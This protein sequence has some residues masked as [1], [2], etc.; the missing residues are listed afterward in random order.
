MKLFDELKWRG[1]IQDV[2][3]PKL[4]EMI[5]KGDLTFYIGTDP[6]AESMHI[7][8]YSSFSVA[9]RLADGGHKP[10]L[11][12]GGATGLIGDPKPNSERPM[13]TKEELEKNYKGLR[14]QV[15]DIFGFEV[16]NNYDW[17]KDINFI[18]YLRDYGKYFSLNYMLAK[19]TVKSRLDIGIT[20]TEFSYMILQ[21]LDFLWLYENKNCLLQIGGQDQWGNITAGIE[22]TRK[23]IGAEVF[24]FT[25]PLILDAHGNKFGKS[26]GNAIWL[27]K[28]LTTPYEM[29]Q[30]FI[31]Q[32][33]KMIIK[34]LKMLSF[35]TPD[36]IMEIEKLHNQ[37]PELRIAQKALAEDIITFLHGKEEF[38]K[39]QEIS[40]KIFNGENTDMMP[41]LVISGSKNIIDV[42]VNSNIAPSKSEARR[43]ITQGGIEID[44]V[45]II[46][47]NYEIVKNEVIIKKGKKSIN[48]IILK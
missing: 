46:D 12:V 8:H 30:F 48:K 20:Y 26:E 18:D 28:N 43:L 10:I 37:K 35:L 23:K 24:A 44:K 25:M 17:S 38:I 22:L 11:L 15:E 29:Y 4:E 45:K 13:I 27:D 34:Y 7:G 21:A 16:V 2:S 41:T 9:K 39:A 40:I 6:T 3:S 31:N 47:P 33:D 5:N 36:E 14:K 19:D 32:D 42:L 1:L